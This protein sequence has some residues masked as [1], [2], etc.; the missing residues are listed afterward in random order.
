M[1]HPLPKWPDWAE[2][3]LQGL[4]YWM[5]YRESLYRGHPVPEAAMVNEACNL[6]YANLTGDFQL[7]C[8]WKYTFLIPEGSETDKLTPKSR[9][10]LIVARHNKVL[11]RNQNIWSLVDSVVEV[12]RGS[13]QNPLVTDD[14]LRLGEF[15]SLNPKARAFLFL[16]SESQRPTRFVSE[17][18]RAILGRNTVESK[19]FHYRVRRACKA[20]KGFTAVETAHYACL[21]EVLLNR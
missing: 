3:A 12:K 13:A 10:D 14:L 2:A 17:K 6:I 5:G 8:E 19:D 7:L 1:Q 21:I 15:K 4:S 16:V 9:A 20:A 18:G 11:P